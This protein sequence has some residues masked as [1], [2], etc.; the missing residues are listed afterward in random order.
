[1]NYQ[2]IYIKN[3]PFYK[4]GDVFYKYDAKSKG[5]IVVSNPTKLPA[6]GTAPIKKKEVAKKVVAKKVVKKP[7][8]KLVIKKDVKAKHPLLMA[9]GPVI[10][11]DKAEKSKVHAK[12]HPKPHPKPHPIAP[13]VQAP[14]DAVLKVEPKKAKVAKKR[15]VVV[16]HKVP[17][18]HSSHTSGI[19][20]P[21]VHPVPPSH[22]AHVGLKPGNV[23]STLPKD[24]H[25]K[26][27]NGVQYQEAGGA[28]YL[29]TV[30]ANNRVVYVV[31]KV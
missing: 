17:A 3:S 23:V 9:P 29:P 24:A 1:M 6:Y 27:V 20:L 2:R 7:V 28:L 22:V 21:P 26:V 19:V 12:L 14:K 11:K 18:P 4:S 16:D 15:K 10:L 30:G 5:F 25:V 31:V 13:I 8:K